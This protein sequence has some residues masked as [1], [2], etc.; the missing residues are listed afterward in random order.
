[1]KRFLSSLWPSLMRT[2]LYMAMGSPLVLILYVVLV[3]LDLER[4]LWY[5][6]AACAVVVYIRNI[7][8][9]CKEEPHD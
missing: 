9:F 6:V 3:I 1:M 4:L 5:I 7:Y 2:L 8:R